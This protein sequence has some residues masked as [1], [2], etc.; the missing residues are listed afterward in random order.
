MN[1]MNLSRST[2]NHGLRLCALLVLF[3]HS[4]C[5][6]VG[7]DYSEPTAGWIDS[8]ERDVL[9]IQA[10]DQST[11]ELSTWWR[12]FED[13]VL[14][15]LI[16]LAHKHNPGL[17]IAGLRILESR[18]ALGISTSLRY[19]Q[20]QQASASLLG[21]S[22]QNRDGGNS[23]EFTQGEA[24]VSIGW[25]LD[26][27]GKFRRSIESADAA[28]FASIANQRDAQVLL[29]AQVADLY[30]AYQTTAL[31]IRIA[32]ENAEIQKRSL[33][34]TEK[35]FDNGQIDEL[36]VQQAKTQ[37]NATLSTIPDL[38]STRFQ[39]RNALCVLLARAPGDLPELKA[40][41]DLPRSSFF[42]VHTVAAELLL[43]RPDVR[44]SAFQVA[45]QSAQ[46]GLAE[47]DKYPSISLLGSLGISGSSIS[48]SEDRISLGIGPA[49]T[50]NI[51]DYGRIRNSVRVEDAGLQI[52]IE[53]FQ[54]VLL[55][56]AQE[57]DDAFISLQQ[58]RAKQLPLTESVKAARRS[59]DLANKSYQ[60]GQVD[61]QRVLDTQR[62]FASQSEAEVV[63]LGV[64]L[65][66][67]I[68][69]YRS[70]GGG[71]SDTPIENL[72]PEETRKLMEE[73]SNWGNLLRAP[74][75]KLPSDGPVP[76][77]NTD[78]E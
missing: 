40:L 71:W 61:F 13:P 58:S 69:L 41:Q 65:S 49:F 48:G 8:W 5:T 38:E 51:F 20:S 32:E 42:Q 31:R 7:P 4:S 46:V 63:N 50:W 47:A 72:L 25:E 35:L 36:D 30:F 23:Q 37:Y 18:A 60:E 1:W 68:D 75:P 21:V 29:S 28:F 76:Q 59:L 43:R 15:E 70:L 27:W 16:L 11:G 54:S 6:T 9:S 14:T 45:A 56:A 17:R 57:M 39:L 62:A 66:A 64:Q 3:L 53:N 10:E 78:N 33:E 24:S 22:Q 52:A 55:L 2:K 12:S 73:R 26:F 19:P 74:L 34:I 77:E 67:L 44:A